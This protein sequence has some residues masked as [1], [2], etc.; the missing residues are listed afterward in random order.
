MSQQ[1]PT[2]PMFIPLPQASFEGE[3]SE[4]TMA[5]WTDDAERMS[6]ELFW[7]LHGDDIMDLWEDLKD[8]LIFA[9]IP[10]NPETNSS[11]F[12]NW[13]YDH[14]TQRRDREAGR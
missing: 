6:I 14:T 8:R 3:G 12:L 2:P 1:P 9:G 5:K 10:L 7:D 4:D 13:V 11:Q